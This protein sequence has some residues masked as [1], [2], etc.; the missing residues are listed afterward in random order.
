MAMSEVLQKMKSAIDARVAVLAKAPPKEDPKSNPTPTNPKDPLV[1]SAPPAP[2]FLSE[3]ELAKQM[4]PQAIKAKLEQ[5]KQVPPEIK[6]RLLRELPSQ[7]PER[8]RRLIGAY[9]QDLLEP[10]REPQAGGKQP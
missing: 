7:F 1:E 4:T 2:V 5:S 6:A 3:E 10:R 8:Y 9:Y